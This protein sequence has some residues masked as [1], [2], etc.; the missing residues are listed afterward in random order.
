[1]PW[2][3]LL[4][5]IYMHGQGHVQAFQRSFDNL[6]GSWQHT[7]L[8]DRTLKIPSNSKVYPVNDNILV[9][10]I[11][12]AKQSSS[13]VFIPTK[14]GVSRG[15]IVGVGEGKTRSFTGQP[16]AP[17]V[18]VGQNI[19]YDDDNGDVIQIGG[20]DH[21]LVN[22]ENILLTYTDD[23]DSVDRVD[24]LRGQLLVRLD[25]GHKGR[26]GSALIVSGGRDSSPSSGVVVKVGGDIKSSDSLKLFK[27][28]YKVKFRFHSGIK[29]LTL[30][31]GHYAIINEN[32]V[33][34]KW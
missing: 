14:F 4:L 20:E 15:S 21:C 27:P 34:A 7:R 12:P 3:V 5:L 16:I 13:G 28:G 29:G 6:G 25:N 1:M 23:G 26:S 18:Q 32:D 33:L 22:I 8:H 2:I 31:D 17:D 11:A 30:K 24:C 19:I 9:K 10:M